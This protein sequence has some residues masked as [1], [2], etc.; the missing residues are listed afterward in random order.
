[1][2]RL[3][4]AILLLP[5]S[6]MASILLYASGPRT[7]SA[8]GQD[9][10]D[11]DVGGIPLVKNQEVADDVRFIRYGRALS[12]EVVY[13]TWP[14]ARR[15]LVAELNVYDDLAPRGFPGSLLMTSHIEGH[16]PVDSWSVTLRFPL[17]LPVEAGDVRY[18]S[19]RLVS[20][21]P[22]PA[23]I[24]PFLSAAPADRA[25]SETIWLLPVGAGRIWRASHY[26]QLGTIAIRVWGVPEPTAWA[27]GLVAML[28]LLI[29]RRRQYG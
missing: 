21:D 23:S 22:M 8:I 2:F 26:D 24:G 27:Y 16:T 3:I 1:M 14:A 13:S 18:F 7:D 19:V 5:S 17:D 12:A 6:A 9:S 29:R 28:G 4:L 25:W 20:V 11:V 15:F 10:C